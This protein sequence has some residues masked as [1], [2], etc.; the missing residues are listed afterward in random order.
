MWAVGDE[1]AHV[2]VSSLCRGLQERKGD[3][4]RHN[5]RAK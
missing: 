4:D 5:G 2:F 3:G 1:L